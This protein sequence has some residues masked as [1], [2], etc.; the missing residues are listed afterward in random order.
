MFC[1]AVQLKMQQQQQLCNYCKY[2]S[3]AE[4]TVCTV[5]VRSYAVLLCSL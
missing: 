3:V 5:F 2:S 1:D 4:C